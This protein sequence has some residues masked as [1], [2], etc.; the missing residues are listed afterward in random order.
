M[1]KLNSWQR[2]ALSHPVALLVS[3]N[4]L[5]LRYGLLRV[6]SASTPASKGSS[7]RAHD[8]HGLHPSVQ[9]PSSS[10]P[11]EHA[12]SI[13]RTKLSVKCRQSS[14]TFPSR[15]VIKGSEPSHPESTE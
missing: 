8:I 4:C 11:H 9:L 12:H 10:L 15:V 5:A 3:P 14:D 6:C 1:L 7:V 13:P 2:L